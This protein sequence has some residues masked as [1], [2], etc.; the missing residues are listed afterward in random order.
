MSERG[1]KPRV[2]RLAA[3][4][5]LAAI[6]PA[7]A[8]AQIA[9]LAPIEQAALARDAFA[10]GLLDRSEGALGTDLWRGSDAAS[11]AVLL[12]ALPSRPPSPS[13]G[14]AMRRVLLSSGDSPPDA[15]AALGGAKL[16]ALVRA[17]FIAEARQ[18]E[19]LSTGVNADPAS[20]EAM[21]N[22]DILAG[23]GAA[24]CDKARRITGA[25]DNPFWVRLRIV[26]YARSNELDAAE[27]ALGI[28]AES[29]GVSETDATLFTALASGGKLKTPVA[30]TDA[31]HFAAIKLMGTPLSAPLL[32]EAEAGV[33]EAVANDSGQG[34][35]TRLAAARSAAAM[36]AMSGAELR[37]LYAAAPADEA[38]AYGEIRSMSA[39]EF[40]RDKAARIAAEI[41]GAR[42][43]DAVFATSVLYTDDIRAVEGALVEAHEAEAFALAR[44]AVGDAVGAERWLAAAA[45]E[46]LRGLPEDQSMRFIDLVG[47]LGVIEPAGA[48]RVA[49]AANVVVAVPRLEIGEADVPASDPGFLVAAAIDAAARGSAGKSALAGLVASKAAAA[50]DPVAEA[51]LTRS[52]ALAGLDDILR[53]RT[54]EQ[55]IAAMFPDDA[56]I[57]PAAAPAPAAG[58]AP[59]SAP[60]GLTPRL[61]PKRTT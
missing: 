59:A 56:P 26:C 5:A 28:L 29:G 12:D 53:R 19:S 27:L 52:L 16:K 18:I 38:G 57:A 24:A 41:A 39:P 20:I 44:L 1:P 30:P 21:A 10:T 4:A 35:P 32:G 45:P 25:R 6:A 49:A 47:V 15:T 34:W 23:D 2:R 42:S 40:L 7:A 60:K 58:P 37:S 46:M 33:V 31:V 17:G 22:A 54:V 9:P 36:G 50:G 3:A 51:V 11:L 61:K 48:Q 55:A 8:L 13:I 43:F 14:A